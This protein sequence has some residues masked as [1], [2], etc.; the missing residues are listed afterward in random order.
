[1]FVRKKA[2]RK[3]NAPLEFSVSQESHEHGEK[4]PK[5]HTENSGVAHV[6]SSFTSR[7]SA[8]QQ[9]SFQLCFVS[10]YVTNGPEQCVL[11]EKVGL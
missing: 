4:N 8:H 11:C 2:V 9:K 5:A 1:V 3:P 10:Q 7:V 6:S